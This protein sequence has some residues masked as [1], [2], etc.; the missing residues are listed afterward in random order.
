V[1]VGSLKGVFG[2]NEVF[3]SAMAGAA[4][5]AVVFSLIG[6]GMMVLGYK[7][8][9]W[10]TPKLDVEKELGENRNVAVAIVIGSLILAVAVVVG[11]V[12]GA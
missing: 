5:N 6:I 12:V 7:V 11:R 9:D 8:F 10:V 3:W 4:V 1:R 2:L